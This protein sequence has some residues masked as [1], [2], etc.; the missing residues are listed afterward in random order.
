MSF[1]YIKYYKFAT[2]IRDISY[3][4]RCMKKVTNVGTGGKNEG[5]G[6]GGKR[7]RRKGKGKKRKGR[8]KN[9][10]GKGGKRT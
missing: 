2:A 7:N 8:G 5:K 1:K 3:H 6:K 9:R 10:K 4:F